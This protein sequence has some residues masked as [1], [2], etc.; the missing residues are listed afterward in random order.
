MKKISLPSFGGRRHII[1]KEKC[2][3]GILSV[4]L[5][6]TSMFY[7]AA[8]KESKVFAAKISFLKEED[9]ESLEE[10]ATQEE[11]NLT[12]F[13]NNYI[14]ELEKQGYQNIQYFKSGDTINDFVFYANYTIIK[15]NDNF[16]SFNTEELADNFINRLFQY[17]K[18]N[19]E[20]FNNVKEQIAEE[21]SEEQLENIILA[22]KKE[23][24]EAKK[25]AA[26]KIKTKAKASSSNK[27]TY[28]YT[29]SGDVTGEMIAEYAQKF[30]GNP[31]KWGG[32]SLTK[33]ADCS[34]FVYTIFNH[35]GIGMTRVGHMNYGTKVSFSELKPRRYCVLW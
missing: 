10:T 13:V 35:F 20:K 29:Y 12:I 17:G 4:L 6:L 34:G 16:Y 30:V 22:K 23:T 25:L 9:V 3:A 26:R 21:T 24:E 1:N 2:L 27:V 31:Y 7:V 5:L 14:A 32:T 18:Q 33:G 8:I 19:Y 28:S 15:L 11:E